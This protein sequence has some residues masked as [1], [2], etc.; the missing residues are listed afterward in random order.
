MKSKS[1]W[2]AGAVTVPLLLLLPAAAQ[3]QLSGAVR[4]NA[5]VQMFAERGLECELLKPWE[6]AALSGM[7]AQDMA[8]R[9]AD[10]MQLM[11]AEA[12][13]LGAETTCDDELLNAWIEGSA[14]GFESEMLP[15]FLVAYA[16]MAQMQNPPDVFVETSGTGELS[17][18][19]AAIEAKIA[20]LQADGVMPEGGQSWPEFEAR[21][22]EFIAGF[23]ALLDSGD[24]ASAEAEEARTMIR[25][26]VEIT[27][28]WLL[29]P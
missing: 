20:A 7:V 23:S 14:R 3:D 13:R 8:A 16:Q 19:V 24:A 26:T 18:A 5:M 29:D 11:T 22:G 28:L 17:A 1:I 4:S 27:E 10:Q 25:Q 9:S 12:D 15:P 21:V 2:V 6:S